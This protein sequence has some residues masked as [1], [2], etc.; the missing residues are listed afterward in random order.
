MSSFTPDGIILD[1]YSEIVEKLEADFR[2]AFGDGVKTTPDSVYGQEI[3]LFAAAIAEQNELIEGIV[4]AFNPQAAAGI[5]LSNLVQ[6]N[7]ITRKEAEFSSVALEVTAGTAPTTI[8]AGSLVSDQNDVNEWALDN[9]VILLPFETKTVSATCTEEGPIEAAPASL[10]KIKTPIYSWETVTNTVAASPGQTEETDTEL[11]ARRSIASQATGQGSEPSIYLVLTE[12][13]G[14]ERVNLYVNKGFAIDPVTSVP[15]QHIWAIVRGGNDLDI[16]KVLVENVAG[17]IGMFGSIPIDYYDEESDRTYRVYF[18]RPTDTN[19]YVQ[20]TLNKQSDY[21][22]DG[23]AQMKQNIIDYYAG[24][25]TIDGR[26]VDGF[27][28]GDAVEFT[29]H[30]TP[31]NAVPGHTVADL[32]VDTVSPPVGQSDIPMAVNEQ[33]YIDE[34]QIEI[35]TS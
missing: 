6:F 5:F 11:R 16:A 17:G 21:P 20:V 8:P 34:T 14:A 29:R 24:D 9:D 27:G 15:P 4:S 31:I 19:I 3:R 13:E 32:R 12:I 30:Y 33:A 10:T 2:A 26:K 23:D 35:L 25:M 1:R 22:S 18:D 7:G 28:I